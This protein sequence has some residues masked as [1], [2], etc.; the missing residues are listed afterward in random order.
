MKTILFVVAVAALAG[1]GGTT[2][3]PTYKLARAQEMV[4]NAEAMPTVATDPKA[5]Q[6]LQLAKSQLDHAKRL[7]IDGENEDARWVLMR[8]EADAE[9]ALYLSLAQA[10]KLDAQQTIESIRQSMAPP[11]GAQCFA[12]GSS[13][14]PH[15]SGLCRATRKT[16]CPNCRQRILPMRSMNSVARPRCSR[17]T[18]G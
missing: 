4:R 9:A 17:S 3:V 7:M 6:H 16:S 11:R 5:T 2:P 12:N 14:S 8:A 15:P 18:W 13:P 10:V 1:C